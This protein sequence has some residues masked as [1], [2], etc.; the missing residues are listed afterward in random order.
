MD[1]ITT[2]EINKDQ[3]FNENHT[4][5]DNNTTNNNSNMIFNCRMYK[6]KYPEV[7]DLVLVQVLNVTEMG[8]YVSLLEYN[9]IEGMILTSE[10]SRRRIKSMNKLIPVNKIEVASVLRVEA[11]KGYIDLSKKRVNPEEIAQMQEKCKKSK[12]VHSM[13][14][15]LASSLN[16]TAENLYELFVWDLYKKFGHAYDAFKLILAEPEKKILE[17]YYL[18]VKIEKAFLKEI[19]HR[20]TL[21]LLKIR[22][23]LEVTCFTYEGIDAIKESLKEAT[24]LSSKECPIRVIVIAA[25]VYLVTTTT[26]H[27]EKGLE[28]IS[29]ACDLIKNRMIEKGGEVVLKQEAK[30]MNEKD[31]RLLNTLLDTLERKFTI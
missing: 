30:V 24:K 22:A 13:I 25:P 2:L 6:N 21:P 7:D 31:E 11:E 16:I 12:T 27:K 26:V 10:L 1:D 19:Q 28:L 20:F 3:Q 29:Q 9:N 8:A 18:D 17:G 14:H 5:N 4:I 23:Q 15:K